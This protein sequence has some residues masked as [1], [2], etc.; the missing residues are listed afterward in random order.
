MQGKYWCAT[1]FNDEISFDEQRMKYLIIGREMCPKTENIH[2][3]IYIEFKTN[4][5]FNS[6]KKRYPTCHFEKRIGTG[7]EAS[8]YCKKDGDY[9][10]YGELSQPEQGKRTDLEEISDKIK[11]NV[12]MKDIAEEHSSSY[13]KY[14]KGITAL[15]N[16]LCKKRNFMP[17][18]IWIWGKAGTGKTRKATEY[19]DYYIWNGDANWWDGYY[20]E[21]NI[22]I[23]DISTIR[24]MSRGF[25]L[26]FCDRYPQRLP[27]K[28]GFIENT[29][30]R[31]IFT[32]NYHWSK[33]FG[34]ADEIKR[35]ISQTIGIGM[36]VAGNTIPPPS[37]DFVET[38]C[39]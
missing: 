18:V 36:E 22:I 10:E 17:E 7:F 8:E 15:K 37:E 1:D 39:D 35:R 4:Q 19:G 33:V 3:Q 31:I 28:G 32:S 5:R 27:I 20:G 16:I 6:L 34:N 24:E 25:F 14:N 2:K 30:E 11:K 12:N 9:T 13:I 26:K 23:D 38:P 29:A 21:P